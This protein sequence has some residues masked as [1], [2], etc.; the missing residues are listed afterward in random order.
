MKKLMFCLVV[1]MFLML[2]PLGVQAYNVTITDPAGDQ[3]GDAGFDTTKIEYNVN[4]NPLVVTITTNYTAAGI[5]VGDWQTYPAD[6]LLWGAASS[7]PALAIPLVNHDSFTAGTLYNVGS[8]YTSDDIAALNGIGSG[9]TWGFGQDVWLKT[10]TS[11]GFGG[12]VAWGAPG[13]TYTSSGWYWSDASPVGDYLGISWATS[14]CANDVVGVPE[15]ATLLLLGF[16]LIGLAT[17]RK[18]IG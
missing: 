5:L 18:R 2:S 4:T 13:V 6:L 11:T 1:G 15:P 12:T 14:T 10:G 9:Y 8:F 17:L 3:L 7:P 16:G